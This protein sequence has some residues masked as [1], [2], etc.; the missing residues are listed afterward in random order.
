MLNNQRFPMLSAAPDALHVPQHRAIYAFTGR[1]ESFRFPEFDRTTI[2]APTPRDQTEKAPR[3]V[4]IR[5]RT[6]PEQ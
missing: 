6:R 2:T 5:Q 3:I 1:K 4:D